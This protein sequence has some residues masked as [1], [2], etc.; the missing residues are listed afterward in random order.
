MATPRQ[1]YYHGMAPFSTSYEGYP[2]PGARSAASTSL[3]AFDVK[4]LVSGDSTAWKVM[5]VVGGAVGA[6]HGY[7]RNNS[8]GW[9]LVWGALGS[10]F[11]IPTAAIGVAQGLGK[12][13]GG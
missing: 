13:K 5:R 10:L 7:K 9:A 12:R 3:G 4:S 11:P 8:V 1:Y 2:L 6:Y